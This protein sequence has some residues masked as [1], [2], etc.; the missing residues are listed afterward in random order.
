MSE[1]RLTDMAFLPGQ[2]DVWPVRR[3]QHG[4]LSCP[5]P[6]IGTTHA[7]DPWCADT[8]R[9]MVRAATDLKRPSYGIH[10]C[11]TGGLAMWPATCGRIEPEWQVASSDGDFQEKAE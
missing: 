9:D 10:P 7:A 2:T 5:G 6:G 8:K 4:L 1:A 11:F 3:F